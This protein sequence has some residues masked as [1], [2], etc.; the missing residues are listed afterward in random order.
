MTKT[1]PKRKM[2][3]DNNYLQHDDLRTY[4]AAS[5]QNY[6]VIDEFVAIDSYKGNTLRSIPLSYA[7]LCQYPRQVILLKGAEITQHYIDRVSNP[8]RR[9][10][11]K[12]QTDDF[13]QF[14]RALKHA[15]TAHVQSQLLELGQSANAHMDLMIAEASKLAV[16]LPT[17]RDAYTDGELRVLRSRVPLPDGLAR[18]IIQ[19]VM[20]LA[21]QRMSVTRITRR[22]T[23]DEAIDSLIFRE[24]MCMYIWTL[25]SVNGSSPSS[26][27]RIRNDVIDA[28]HAAY[29][30]FFDGLLSKDHLPNEIYGVAR[31]WL[32]TMKRALSRYP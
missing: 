15:D 16:L 28:T 4:L 19:Q 14:C 13:C 10:I 30:T 21:A 27:A 8:Q 23:F 5:G 24:Q 20:W 7:I 1:I 3:I 6:V 31:S 29:A 12:E 2:V 9:L 17:L 18:K 25:F 11:A 22:P 26:P 32:N